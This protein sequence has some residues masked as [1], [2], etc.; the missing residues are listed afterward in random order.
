MGILN[1]VLRLFIKGKEHPI[2]K[3]GL[4][5]RRFDDNSEPYVADRFTPPDLRTFLELYSKSPWVYRCANVIAAAAA[6]VRYRLMSDG[7]E[8]KPAEIAK[9]MLKPNPH[10][11]WFELI[12]TTFLHMEL[13]GNCYWEIVRGAP[14]DGKID[15]IF[16][17]RPDR[18]EIVPDD[19]KKIKEYLYKVDGKDAIHYK[20]EEI[21]HHKYTDAL[22]EFQGV[23]SMA[24]GKEDVTLDF[25]MKSWNKRFF[26]EGGEPGGV[27]E[28]AQSLTEQAYNRLLSRWSKRHKGVNKSHELAILEEGLTYKQITAKH[29]EMQYIES[30]RFVRDTI[31]ALMG[32]PPVIAGLTDGSTYANSNDQ[33]KTFWMYNIIPKLTHLAESINTFLMTEKIS[34][35]FITKELL[36]I[37]EDEAIKAQIAQTNVTHGIMTQN[38]ARARYWDLPPVAYGDVWYKPVG[39][40]DVNEVQEIPAPGATHVGNE[41]GETITDDDETGVQ[42]P[43]QVPALRRI[44]PEDRRPVARREVSEIE[45]M[46]QTEPNWDN[47]VEVYDYQHFVVLK[48]ELGP[49]DRK[50][51]KVLSDFFKAQ[52]EEI[53]NK[54]ASWP[55]QKDTQGPGDVEQFLFDVVAADNRLKTVLIPAEQQIYKKY[56]QKQLATLGV[57]GKMNLNNT[58]VEDFFAQRAANRV[59]N[60]NEGTREI[61]RQELTE[62]M[63][64]HESGKPLLSRIDRVFEGEISAT[65]AVRI[66]RT[67]VVATSNQAKFEAAKQ[68]G[69]VV[70]KRWICMLLPTT[71]KEI[72]GANHV[73]MHGKVV[74][75]EK[76]FQVPNR[77]GGFDEMDCPGDDAGSAENVVNCL[78]SVNYFAGTEAFAE[79]LMPQE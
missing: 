78:C 52:G 2:T 14:G 25:Y 64:A 27:L 56:G 75:F 47:P 39:L 65:R 79:I 44:A 41:A 70:K 62:A 46:E 1:S 57:P 58:R 71:R 6:S 45:K 13:T 51:R 8:I 40:I 50:V 16:I 28:T 7:K 66:A 38:E 20:P 53:K 54:L 37:I 43:S 3:S 61:L 15:A 4:Q 10:M 69:V 31:L 34:L 29:A 12:E 63:A 76:K 55:I 18:M 26:K 21:L 33:K 36:S 35:E 72:G 74:D 48:S 32:V 11:T 30:Q 73:L 42:S 68:S 5:E 22:N 9:W 23:S 60:I 49:D 67:E 77:S 59:R 17:L 19:K 24:A